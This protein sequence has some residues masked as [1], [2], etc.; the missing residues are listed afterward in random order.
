LIG[1]ASSLLDGASAAC[2][3]PKQGLF[4]VQAPSVSSQ[5]SVC[6]HDTM[7]GNKQRHRV[8]GASTRHS[9]RRCRVADDAGDLTVGSCRSGRDLLQGL[10]DL[11]LKG[12]SVD[13]DQDIAHTRAAV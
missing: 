1:T 5:A 4:P 10:P 6:S 11:E 8:A 2:F 13:V 9:A 7:A 3:K 12:G